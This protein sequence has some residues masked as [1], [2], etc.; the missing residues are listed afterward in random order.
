MGAAGA[1]PP[2]DGRPRRARAGVGVAVV[3]A[4]TERIGLPDLVYLPL[5]DIAAD[6]EVMTLSRPDEL[7]GPVRALVRP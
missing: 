6:V 2:D 4:A 5:R 1:R 3:P 7:A